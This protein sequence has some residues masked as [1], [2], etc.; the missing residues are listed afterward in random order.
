M[1]AFVF[2][3]VAF[4]FYAL[5]AALVLWKHSERTINRWFSVY[6]GVMAF[7]S[8]GITS[9]MLP[10]HP[11]SLLFWD[12][13]AIACAS[14]VPVA[15]W[16]FVQ[17]YTGKSRPGLRG[18]FYSGYA[19]I[20]VLN[21]TNQ[22]VR[23][24]SFRYAFP[25]FEFTWG[26]FPLLVLAGSAVSI[27][28]LD[29]VKI[30]RDTQDPLQRNQ[31]K[32]L[33]T[34]SL[35][36]FL[37]SL[38]YFPGMPIPSMDFAAN[39]LAAILIAYAILRH[40]LA[41]INILFKKAFFGVI[42]IILLA[43]IYLVLILIFTLVFR[44]N[45]FESSAGRLAIAL[46]AAV[47]AMLSYPV[48]IQLE[49]GLERI[50][51][52][53]RYRF[54]QCLKE[55]ET[56]IQNLLDVPALCQKVV[57][58]LSTALEGNPV[59]FWILNRAQS[60]FI[61]QA[62]TGI[63]RMRISLPTT[64]LLI[65]RLSQTDTPLFSKEFLPLVEEIPALK[66]C[67]LEVL[68]PLK[69]QQR[70]RGM[71]GIGKKENGKAYSQEEFSSLRQLMEKISSAL[72]N[73][74]T[75]QEESR[76]REVAEILQAVILQIT[77][78]IQLEQVLDNILLHLATLIEYDS[79]CIF[80][81]QG[82]QLV[83]VAAR[84]FAST[85]KVLGK[86]Y[87]V[88]D[89]ALFT[90]MIQL[91]RPLLIPEV[92]ERIPFRGYGGT[93]SVRSWIGVPLIARGVVI[94]CLTLDHYT[95][96]A[97]HNPEQ[98][99]LVQTFAN[100][101]SIVIENSRLMKVEREQRLLAES[102]REIGSVL[103]STLDMERLL[104]LLVEQVG[105]LVP[106][107]AVFLYLIEKNTPKL[108]R[109]RVHETVPHEFAQSLQNTV[110][111]LEKSPYFSALLDSHEPVILPAIEEHHTW[112]QSAIPLGAWMGA[113][114]VSKNKAIACFSLISLKPNI[115][116]QN[117]VNLMATFCS[118]AA[119]A[120]QNARLFSEVQQLATLD[121]LTRILNRRQLFL[122]G[123]REFS[124]ARRYKRP[125]SLLM[126]DLDRFK[127]INDTFGH[128]VGDE[129]LKTLAHILRKAIREV[130]IFGRYGGEEFVLVLPETRR[131]EAIAIAERLRNMVEQTPV[132]TLSG[133]LRITVSIGVAEQTEN[134][135]TFE[136]LVAHADQALYRAKQSGRNRVEGEDEG[137]K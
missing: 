127:E 13:F 43:L 67:H 135:Q 65:Q 118:E 23:G 61:L 133:E 125:L 10:G 83:A 58:Q 62:E 98:A 113:P 5:L 84:G 29:L 134:T 4:L 52:P 104:D 26:Y 35:L 12:H 22:L 24:I 71:I 64:H 20:Q 114:V 97:Y 14:F 109:T 41:D 78:N 11:I 34:A 47:V 46:L 120:L 33:M 38:T 99:S 123:K 15:F 51:Y 2:G 57:E 96:N 25:V 111:H 124:R 7:W 75:L 86:S 74:I 45:W 42:G 89:D 31:I 60:E 126:I 100:H 112:I 131:E 16:E 108:V 119:L 28:T 128:P 82:D 56:D 1:I 121:D 44:I 92:N 107:S 63:K 110:F 68:F 93:Q 129:A 80:L 88:L 40:H 130:D 30:Y 19:F 50:F 103:D 18:L 137:N 76:R 117:H 116:T 69:S 106:Y 77:P 54:Q 36:I 70:L 9:L 81:L 73:A 91:R 59:A 32:Y 6:L 79:A 102:L 115:Y 8:L 66:D 122:E 94:G 136:E 3:L 90:Q 17:V 87:S 55:L 105:R 101:A 39:L 49:Q 53:R 37:G 85:E 95:P 132:N 48:Y 72:E 21:L 27:S